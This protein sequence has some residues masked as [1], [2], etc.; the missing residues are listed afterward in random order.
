MAKNRTYRI[1]NERLDW[2]TQWRHVRR[3]MRD[4]AE[5]A[6]RLKRVKWADDPGIRVLWNIACEVAYSRAMAG[7]TVN[8][9]GKVLA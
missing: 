7:H 6:W 1:S 4:P 2:M 9:L 5:M 8:R 3:T